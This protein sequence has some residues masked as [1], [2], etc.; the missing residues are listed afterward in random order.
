MKLLTI[1]STPTVL[2]WDSSFY[3]EENLLIVST[4]KIVILNGHIRG[5]QNLQGTIN[6]KIRPSRQG[7][8]H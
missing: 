5:I 7:D 2:Q 8:S 3:I 6:V 1:K 4:F